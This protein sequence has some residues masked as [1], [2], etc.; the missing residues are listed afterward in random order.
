MLLFSLFTSSLFLFF[1]FF[2]G[3]VGSFKLLPFYH[4]RRTILIRLLSLLLLL[5][6]LLLLRISYIRLSVVT[7]LLDLVR[8]DSVLVLLV[9]PW[10][11]LLLLLLFVPS[12]FFFFL[13]LSF[14]LLFLSFFL[15]L[16]FFTFLT[17]FFSKTGEDRVEAINHKQVSNEA[18]F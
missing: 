18:P 2:L 17:L 1:A 4:G 6:L 3:C 5:L 9:L 15:S 11:P 14:F 12:S 8:F 16:S 10:K 13:F 7:V